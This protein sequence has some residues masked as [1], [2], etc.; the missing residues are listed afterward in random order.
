MTDER[1]SDLEDLVT[2]VASLG[3][4]VELDFGAEPQPRQVRAH[5]VGGRFD[6]PK[7]RRSLMEL[8]RMRSG[9]Q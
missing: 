7:A 2:D 1:R 5:L 8:L 3:Y 9:T 4:D 6:L